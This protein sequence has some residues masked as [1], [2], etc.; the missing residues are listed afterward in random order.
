VPPSELTPQPT[1]TIVVVD[2][3]DAARRAL[4]RELGTRYGSEYSIVAT[5]SAAD[6][7]R[8]LRELATD[9]GDVALI[10]ADRGMGGAAI[11]DAV[12]D[13]HPRA[14]RG[15]L[16]EWGEI[17]SHREEIAEAFALRHADCCVTKPTVSPDER[18]HRSITELLDE[19]WRIHGTVFEGARIVGERGS[20]RSHEIC[21]LLQRHDFPYGFY[22]SDSEAGRAVL[23][24]AGATTDR[25][26]VVVLHDGRTLVD[27][28]NVEFADA[29]G[30][31]TRAGTGV[32]DLVVVGGGP[33]GLAAAVSA[34]SEGL[35]TALIE[36]V[37]M[38]GQAGTSSMIRNYLGFPRGISGVELAARAFEQA[39]LFGTEMIYGS[40]AVALRAEPPRRV[41]TLSDGAEL[42]T[43]SVVIASGV[44]YRRL[45]V[46]E[47]EP[48]HGAGVFYGAG[49]SEARSL[50]DEHVCVVGGGNS[51]GQAAVHF[52]KFAARVT[53]LVRSDSLAHSMSEYLMTELDAT[54]NIAV[55]YGTEIVGGGGTGRLEWLDLEHR[56]SRVVE[57]TPAAAVFVLIGA[58][59]HTGWLPPSVARDEWG[60]V[61]TG[62]ECVVGSRVAD[63][64]RYLDEDHEIVIPA[65]MA[66]PML[67]ET[68]LPGVF[69][70]GDVRQGSVKRVASAAGEG[71][72][73]VRLVHEYLAGVP[74]PPA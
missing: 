67:F 62:H 34:E 32:Y 9:G 41:V 5:G 12:R 7:V 6:A 54:P 74:S 35:R 49:M 22:T 10:L 60:Y 28:S 36:P 2:E 40:R 44:S 57:R 72:I 68:T 48:F 59:P 63:D 69:A 66:P 31:R 50:K 61:L 15:L 43:R 58:A 17:R 23:R 53:V 20:P 71:A 3:N 21:D 8:R 1:P 70:V 52:A 14:R 56:A 64:A 27:P 65:S 30:A 13:V 11:L 55:R 16:L 47:L 46:P 38:G 24:A 18:F 26:P 4:T 42:V 37:A 29:V 51:A 33:A 19:W 25:L 39:I 45:D 73:C